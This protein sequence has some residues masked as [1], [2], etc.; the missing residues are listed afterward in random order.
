MKTTQCISWA[1]TLITLTITSA[2]TTNRASAASAA[3]T[4]P[5]TAEEI[6]PPP[7]PEVEET[8]E[9]TPREAEELSPLVLGQGEQR[10][11]REPGLVRYSLGSTCI[12]AHRLESQS[13]L[14][15]K[16][17][18]PGSG[19]LWVWKQD[20]RAEHRSV[21]VEKI[22]SSELSPILE[23]AIG[24]LD[25][26]EVLMA[27]S[28]VVLRGQVGN[29][30]ESAKI[31]ALTE[32]FPKEVHDE[33]EPTEEF[34]KTSEKKLNAWIVATPMAKDLKLE[35]QG[36]A[37][38]VRGSFERPSLQASAEKAIRR[39]YP[40][41]SVELDSLPDSSPTVYFRVFLLELKKSRFHSLGLSW[42]AMQEGAFHV[43][44]SAIS[45]GLA[46]DLALNTLEGEGSLRILSNPELVVRAPGEAEL[47]AG[48]E[49][50]IQAK[51]QFYSNVTWKNY[52][53][54]LR[55][56]VTQSA[57][58]KVRLEIF[59]EVS[60]L[61]PSI[62]QDN[63]PGIQANRMK[64][65]VD[66]RYGTPLLLSGLLQQNMR[67]QA[68]GLPLLRSIPVLG[69]LFGSEDY[70][71]ERSELVAIL[72]P[73]SAPPSNPMDRIARLSPRGPTPPP[74]QWVSAERERAL[75]ESKNWPWNALQ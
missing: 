23:K 44:T 53:L 56:K 10:L 68:K 18:A 48:G 38:F 64:T 50:P 6:P 2:S 17:A 25:E 8:P 12:H 73:A 71:Q 49:I 5:P 67:E 30:R 66:A 32:N 37:L 26:T 63:I 9:N 52:G 54:T 42:P 13:A 4:Q 57:G 69:A 58:E 55:L 22:A 19:D 70:L 1:L 62:G 61:D 60:H 29:L 43:T 28:G 16:G 45:D 11:L 24:H 7:P 41:A 47:F 27:G 35:R 14:L 33:T 20:G 65:Q 21:R 74:R 34:L 31:R 39:I 46:L 75:R 51:S 15:I 40:Q 72:L 59:T 3:E 36:P